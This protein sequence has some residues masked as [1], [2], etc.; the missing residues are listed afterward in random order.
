LEFW[1]LNHWYSPLYLWKIISH[2]DCK[3]TTGKWGIWD[4]FIVTSLNFG[5]NLGTT[6]WEDTSLASIAANPFKYRRKPNNKN[7]GS[8]FS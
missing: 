4:L 1:L 7:N 8:K 6:A 5:S 3:K 2:F